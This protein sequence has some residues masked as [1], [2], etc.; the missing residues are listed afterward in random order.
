MRGDIVADHND[1]NAVNSIFSDIDYS[2]A[3]LYDLF[4]FP[5][6]GG[7]NVLLAL[8][9]ASVPKPACWTRTCCTGFKYIPSAR[10]VAA[11]G[12]YHRGNGAPLF[13]RRQ[14]EISRRIED[15]GS[16]GDDRYSTTSHREFLGFPCGDFST[17]VE[18]DKVV[19]I[20]TPDG[21]VIQAFIGGRDDAFFNDLLGSFGPS[22]TR[23]SS[24]TC[25]TR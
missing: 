23:R 7:A 12:E 15:R 25:R 13:R 9:F 21:Q 14:R 3:D 19:P 22:T 6:A 16:A 17:V 4:G 5:T 10:S 1:P 8:T 11:A 20:P 18:F 2:A 24:T